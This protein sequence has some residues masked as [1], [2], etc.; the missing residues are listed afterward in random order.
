MA[1]IIQK[2]SQLI[3]ES[4]NVLK[5][6][7]EIVL[8]PFIAIILSFCLLG[9][10][11][12]IVLGPFR[13]WGVI[14]IE[15]NNIII[16]NY[17]IFFGLIFFYYL[18]AHF[19]ATFFTAGLITCA[20]LRFRGEN[21]TARDGFKNAFNYIKKIFI[22]TLISATMGLILNIL[23]R[24]SEKLKPKTLRMLGGIFIFLTSIAW[25]LLT[26]FIVPVM[27]F[28]N[29]K[30]TEA[31]KRS[32]YL[33]KKTW[34]EN[35][36]AQFSIAAYFAIFLLLGVTALYFVLASGLSIG[37]IIP[38][39]AFLVIC[40]LMFLVI[41]QAVTGVLKTAL[42][43]YAATGKVPTGFSKKSIK[44]AFGPKFSTNIL[45]NK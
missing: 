2:S 13:S 22:W 41:F 25:R 40:I 34:G 11:V 28:E 4:F 35:V 8:F 27:I 9:L 23:S 7:K 37:I 31:I 42:Y 1:K 24:L 12:L 6:D 14:C 44:N 38:L 15:K 32:G 39:A 29:K 10:Y 17:I 18:L 19:L 36:V 45:K 21:P 30:G 33:F 16:N 20:Y 43:V 26:F 5:K 3:E